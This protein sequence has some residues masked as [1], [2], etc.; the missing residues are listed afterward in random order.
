MLSQL[1]PCFIDFQIPTL[2]QEGPN[3][4]IQKMFLFYREMASMV[5]L[6]LGDFSEIFLFLFLF[7]PFPL[8]CYGLPTRTTS[9]YSFHSRNSQ[10]PDTTKVRLD[11][12]ASTFA[13]QR[14]RWRPVPQLTVLSGEKCWEGGGRRTSKV[15]YVPG[16]V[17]IAIFKEPLLDIAK[18]L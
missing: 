13:R 10:T 3:R 5:A 15:K 17:C 6:S 2:Y 7:S 11:Y 12:H 1:L 8:L 9:I 16:I 18:S 14:W 4:T